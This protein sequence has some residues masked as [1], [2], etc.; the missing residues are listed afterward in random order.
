MSNISNVPISHYKVLTLPTTLEPNS[1]YYVLDQN[2]N[3]VE[4][5]ITSKY[6]IPVPL[7]NTITA[8]GNVDSVTGTGVTG[9]YLNPKVNI[10]HFIGEQLGN[11]I[12]LSTLDGKLIVSPITSPNSSINVN[13]T[14]TELQIQLASYIQQQIEEA[15]QPG[16]NIS[17][18]VNDV[19]YITIS[20]VE[21]DKN[22]TYTQ[23][24]PDSVWTI[25]HPL[26]KYPSIVVIDSSGRVVNGQEDYIDTTKVII[27]FNSE[28]SGIAI[29]N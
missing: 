18:L 6:G 19:G 29:L 15:L 20:D 17:N 12:E 9:T 10:S 13:K 28:F 3:I 11:Q 21:Q 7:F 14:A 1:V 8:G 22:F 23:N 27:T 24:N 5:Y 26:N 4:G 2:T 16:D 25:I